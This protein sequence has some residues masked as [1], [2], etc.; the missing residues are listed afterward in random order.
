[1][2]F[3]NRKFHCQI[4][5]ETDKE[6]IQTENPTQILRLRNGKIESNRNPATT[7]TVEI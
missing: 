6:K 3:D 4:T 1:M 7:I 2:N 5:V